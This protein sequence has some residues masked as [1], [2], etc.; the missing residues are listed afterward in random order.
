M[1]GSIIKGWKEARGTVILAE[2][3]DLLDRF[4]RLSLT[5]KLRMIEFIGEFMVM[6]HKTHG[7][8]RNLP[9]DKRKEYV[10]KFADLGRANFQTDPG[11]AF[12]MAVISCRIETID[13]PGPDAEKAS[14]LLRQLIEIALSHYLE[15]MDEVG[16]VAAIKAAKILGVT[17]PRLAAEMANGGE[18]DEIEWMAVEDKWVNLWGPPPG[19]SRQQ[20]FL[21]ALQAIKV[22]YEPIP[23]TE[24][25]STALPASTP[26]SP[27]RNEPCAC[28]SGKRFKHCHGGLA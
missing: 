18:I 22:E 25:R 21:E 28:G 10:K 14:I 2:T 27:R 3:N 7:D 5:A 8:V 23:P 6:V 11:A 26:S 9:S 4:T 24:P 19:L 17:E 20:E 16:I 1:F 13:T 12:G 15:M